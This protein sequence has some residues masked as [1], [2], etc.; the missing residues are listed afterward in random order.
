MNLVWQGLREAF[1]LIVSGDPLVLSAAWRSVWISTTAVA[2]A[3]ILG[4]PLGVLLA[5]KQFA[6]QATLV[7]L[8]RVAMALPTVFVGMLCYA[9]FSRRGPLGP[10]ELLYSPWGIVAGELLLALPIVIGLTHG[11]IK[12][13]DPRV[14]ETAFTLGASPWKRG[15]T[16][17]SEARTGV[18]LAIMTAFARC[19]TELGIAMIVGGNLKDRTRTLATATALE[20]GRGEFARGLAMSSILLLVAL[21]AFFITTRLTRE[22]N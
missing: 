21:G 4:L 5:R 1:H 12:S 9:M 7:L 8:A 16:Y 11:A 19:V 20:T 18:L 14:G 15:L 10:L 2:I 13:L 17:L 3:A 6:G 22:K